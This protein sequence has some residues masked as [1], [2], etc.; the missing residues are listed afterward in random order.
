MAT[1]GHVAP[2]RLA[3]EGVAAASAGRAVAW[4]GDGRGGGTRVRIGA[5]DADANAIANVGGGIASFRRARF[6]DDDGNLGE[7]SRPHK[8]ITY[9]ELVD[10]R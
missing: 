9:D 8:E 7:S 4:E 1:Y 5:D 2:M 3:T 6:A 10:L